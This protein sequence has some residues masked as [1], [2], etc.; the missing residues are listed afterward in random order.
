[1]YHPTR[2]VQLTEPQ[3]QTTSLHD[4][5]NRLSGTLSIMNEKAV[6]GFKKVART[7]LAIFK[8]KWLKIL[9][10]RFRIKSRL[11]F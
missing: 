5:T 7:L 2:L 9:C 1:M 8:N 3:R 4:N 10:T 11:I 6:A